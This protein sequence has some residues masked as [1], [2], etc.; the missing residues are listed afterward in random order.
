MKTLSK[1]LALGAL[2][3]ILGIVPAPTAT[4]VIPEVSY[5]P[6]EEPLDVGGTVLQPGV[7]V[8]KVVPNIANRNILQV[9]N[10]EQTK[11]FATVLSIPHAVSATEEQTNTQFIFFPASGNSP[12]A[13]RTWFNAESTSGGGH[14]IV[15]PE[16]RAVEIA[17][18]ANA[19]VVAYKDDTTIEEMKTTELEL[20]TPDQKIAVYVPPPPPAQIAMVSDE[21]DELPR[22]AGN[23]PL[24]LTLGLLLVVVAASA[25][26]FRTT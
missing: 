5:L 26:A 10:E 18:V 8:I 20:V 17:M 6:V 12:R 1:L 24:F 25:R 15:Y 16:R 3:V 7:Y 23:G 22:T 14:D 13:L 19:P 4:A 9:L 2:G 11:V 21:D